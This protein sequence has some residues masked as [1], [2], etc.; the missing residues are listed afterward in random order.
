MT[1]VIMFPVKEKIKPI[2]SVTTEKATISQKGVSEA[3]KYS[4]NVGLSDRLEMWSPNFFGVS[5]LTWGSGTNSPP[6]NITPPQGGGTPIAN[7]PVAE[8]PKLYAVAA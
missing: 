4:L 5:F 2:E 8:K 6:P 3:P 1:N 7:R